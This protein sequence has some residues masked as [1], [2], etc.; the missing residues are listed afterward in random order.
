M[1]LASIGVAGRQL[2][3]SNGSARGQ[4]VRG[5]FQQLAFFRG[6]IGGMIGGYDK[7]TCAT[8]MLP[9]ATPTTYRRRIIWKGDEK[10]GMKL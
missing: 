8:M 5:G 3:M 7:M 9:L 6:M 2:W 10:K 4:R 1:L